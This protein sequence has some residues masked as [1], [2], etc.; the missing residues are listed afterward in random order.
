M[1]IFASLAEAWNQEA[2][3]LLVF[4]ESLSE[5]LGQHRFFLPRLYAIP[6]QNQAHSQ[7]ASPLIN[8]YC[9]TDGRKD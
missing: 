6:G 1:E 3:V 7:H 2:G 4:T 5:L 9:R 8:Y